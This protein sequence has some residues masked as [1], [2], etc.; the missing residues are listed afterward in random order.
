[1]ILIGLVHLFHV[2]IVNKLRCLYYSCIAY[3]SELLISQLDLRI[4]T[5]D[6]RWST[7]SL[8]NHGLLTS[9]C[10][11]NKEVFVPTS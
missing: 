9:L 4:F 11:K 1:M 2:D 7:S 5:L 8:Y 6:V 10:I 3:I